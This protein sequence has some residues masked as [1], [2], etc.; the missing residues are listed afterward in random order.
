VT[1]SGFTPES[2][3][4]VQLQVGDTR[5]VRVVMRVQ[6][7]E[8]TVTVEGVGRCVTPSQSTVVDAELVELQPK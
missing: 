6:G 1:S 2:I 3:E 5:S 8:A 4:A 7:V